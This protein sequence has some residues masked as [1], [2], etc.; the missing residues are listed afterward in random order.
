[1][2]GG[3][4]DG[5]KFVTPYRKSDKNDGN[6]AEATCEAVARPSMRFVPVTSLE[7]LALLALHR[8]RQGFVVKRKA[9]IGL[10]SD[11]IFLRRNIREAGPGNLPRV[12]GRVWAGRDAA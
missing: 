4:A 10:G 2:T 11:Y 3:V 9:T 1:L 6:D 8:V 7:H 12:P 5:L